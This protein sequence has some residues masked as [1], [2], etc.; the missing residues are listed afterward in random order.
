M[1]I[2][3]RGLPPMEIPIKQWDTVRKL[4]KGS[5]VSWEDVQPLYEVGTVL[6]FHFE[7]KTKTGAD[8]YIAKALGVPLGEICDLLGNL[9]VGFIFPW[10]VKVEVLYSYKNRDKEDQVKARVVEFSFRG[11][12]NPICA[13]YIEKRDK[14]FFLAQM[15][16]SVVS[17]DAK[18]KG[19]YLTT[20]F[21][22]TLL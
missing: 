11:S 14:A 18:N 8:L 19:E 1:Q 7:T 9:L 15:A 21:T 5:T 4:L 10:R 17:D 2:H 20:R 13:D 6:R 22:L 16:E 12:I 3:G